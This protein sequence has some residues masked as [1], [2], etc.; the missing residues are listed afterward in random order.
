M[1]LPRRITILGVPVDS[2]TLDEAVEQISCWLAQGGPHQVVTINP[3]F[4]MEARHNPVFRAVLLQ[5]D[6]ATPD[7]FGLLLAARWRGT[8]LRGRVTGVALVEAIAALCA[9]QGRSLFLL[10]AAAG[11]AEQA[12]A[13]LS[14]RHQGLRI[15]GC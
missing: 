12:A 7:G 14:A 15:A 6:M 9:H 8:P 5:A 4:V 13:V 10:G 1:H 3:E 2:I 11:V